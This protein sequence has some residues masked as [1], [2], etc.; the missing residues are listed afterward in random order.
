MLKSDVIVI[1]GGAA[2][3][4][5]AI[6]A[7]KRGRSVQV[8]EHQDRVG[9]KIAISG[10]G[11]CN[12]T[13]I[14]TGPANFISANPHFCK[15]ALARYTPADFISLVEK[16]GIAYHEKKLGQL[17]CDGSAQQ[18]IDML[19]GECAAAGVEVRCGCQVLSVEREGAV[20]EPGAS[21]DEHSREFR[22]ET[23]LGSF[24]CSSL[25]IATGGLSIAPLGAT[26]FGYRIARQFGLRIE[27]ARPG[28]VPFTLTP[29][30]QRQ[31][32]PLSGVSVDAV[33]SAPRPQ[34]R[35][36]RA[37][38]VPAFRENILITHRGLSGPAILQISNY[39][40]PGEPISINLLPDQDALAILKSR[41]TSGSGVANLLAQYLPRRFANAWCELYASS[42][43][44]KQY[45]LAEFQELAGRIH[46]LEIIPSGTE[47]FKKAE[48]TAGGVATTELSSQTME[49][50][51][52]PG[53]YFIGE[54][55]DVTGQLGGYNFQW[56]WASGYAAGQAV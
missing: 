19:L 44:L 56:A 39:W 55:V 17:F 34:Q 7:G 4:F 38:Q 28:L 46:N 45:N 2:G 3:L 29:E 24:W 11:R 40:R 10:G 12:F 15:S 9:K 6:E 36:S 43:P 1:G 41:Q 33:V 26:D 32:A 14:H 16:H 30:L 31:L 37:R 49:A 50:K 51:R 52:V 42:R 48:V 53:L 20:T 21:V 54:V 22:I 35:S 23:N 5:C 18:I 27:E 25:V 8:L 47:G 13:N